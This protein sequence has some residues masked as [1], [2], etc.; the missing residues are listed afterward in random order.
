MAPFVS[1]MFGCELVDLSL[2]PC[3]GMMQGRIAL[4]ADFEDCF[5]QLT[6]SQTN[7]HLPPVEPWSAQSSTSDL[8]GEAGLLGCD[9]LV[10]HTS[11]AWGGR[12]AG[13]PEPGAAAL[14]EPG[15]GRP[16]GHRAGL[17][18]AR[19]GHHAHAAAQARSLLRSLGSLQCIC[20]QAGQPG[21]ISPSCSCS[22]FMLW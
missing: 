22:L 17:Q 20:T 7:K 6:C 9:W 3:F 10:S 18:P 19:P 4:R 1:G 12:H 5:A 2:Q 15:H 8:N 11:C 21:Q 13:D 14:G 16:A